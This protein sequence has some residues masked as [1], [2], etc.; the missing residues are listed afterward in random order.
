MLVVYFPYRNNYLPL[1]STKL[2]ACAPSFASKET[3]P[4]HA[5][6]R[7]RK[8]ARDLPTPFYFVCGL[9]QSCAVACGVCLSL[10]LSLQAQPKTGFPRKGDALLVSP[11]FRFQ[12]TTGLETCPPRCSNAA[13]ARLKPST[14]N[15]FLMY[16]VKQL[17][18][19]SPT[20]ELELCSHKVSTGLEKCLPTCRAKQL[21]PRSPT[22][23]PEKYPQKSRQ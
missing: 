3:T 14:K 21:R 9:L 1:A 5:Y 23:E 19:R 11:L 18:P 7:T 4:P 13:R 15:V 20:P 22:A 17:Y 12:V 6:N 8:T 16:R 10:L 2:E